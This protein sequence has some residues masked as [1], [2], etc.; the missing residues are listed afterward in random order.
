MSAPV[1]NITN[2][3]GGGATCDEH[4]Q[5]ATNLSTKND[6]SCICV[7][8]LSSIGLIANIVTL[9][10]FQHARSRK[11]YN[12]HKTWNH[13]TVFIWNLALIDSLSALNMTSLYFSFVFSPES[14]NN[15]S[16]CLIT[17]TTRDICVLISTSSITCIA[18][19]S[20]LGVTKNNLLKDFCDSSFKL[21][22][23]FVSIWIIGTLEYVPKM[24]A[25]YYDIVTHHNEKET[26]D[27]GT[28]FHEIN[29]S[30]VTVYTEFLF[31]LSELLIILLSNCILTIYTYIVTNRIDGQREGSHPRKSATMQI[32]L[33][34]CTIYILQSTPYMVCRMFFAES[35]RIGFFIQFPIAQRVMYTL[36]YTQYLPNMIIYVTRNKNFRNAYVLWFKDTY[37][38]IERVFIK[39]GRGDDNSATQIC[40][41]E[42]NN[43]PIN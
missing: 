21:T 10:A 32:S 2:K 36:Y 12:F 24:F 22:F 35:L 23:L 31:L 42:R 40:M 4:E 39:I 18:V 7:L 9:L 16:W 8:V 33:L 37:L 11:K 6:V 30:P 15:L 25:I 1:R 20:L 29:L 13:S 19:I 3:L 41:K 34:I 14:I 43:A 38:A 26:F 27:C 5:H 17:I 28:L